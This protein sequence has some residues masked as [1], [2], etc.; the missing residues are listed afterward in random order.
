MGGS[1]AAWH[2]PR[3]KWVA[4]T[5]L[6][7]LLGRLIPQ[8]VAAQNYRAAAS[9]RSTTPPASLAAPWGSRSSAA[10]S[11]R[12]TPGASAPIRRWRAPP[13]TCA[14]R[15]KS[16]WPPQRLIGQLPAGR[17]TDVHDAVNRAFLDGLQVA[18]LVCAGIAL[19][20]AVIVAALL[21]A[22]ARQFVGRHRRA[23]R[24]APAVVQPEPIAA[25]A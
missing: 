11:R 16:R 22:R 23:R 13:R 3:L 17:I 4:E 15:W 9:R 25:P 5:V 19:G 1:R 24:P 7:A 6:A 12:C 20:A 21:P 14:P 2:N 10:S 8:I 18:S